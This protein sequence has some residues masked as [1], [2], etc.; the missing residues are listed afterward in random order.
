MGGQRV[1]QGEGAGG[2]IIMRPYGICYCATSHIHTHTHFHMCIQTHTRPSPCGHLFSVH[3][4]CRPNP[5]R[6]ISS[7]PRLFMCNG[8]HL[9]PSLSN[10]QC[11][12]LPLPFLPCLP[13]GLPTSPPPSFREGSYC[14]RNTPTFLFPYF[15]FFFFIIISLFSLFLLISSTDLF[16]DMH[17]RF[18]T[19]FSVTCGAIKEEHTVYNY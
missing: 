6:I 19:V 7:M 8:S 13:P 3:Q 10:P 18:S 14:K 17:C 12:P 1:G 4:D 9:T 2:G 11:S 5:R 15:I 16:L